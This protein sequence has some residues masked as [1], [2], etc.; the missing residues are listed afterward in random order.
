MDRLGVRVGDKRV[1]GDRDSILEGRDGK[2]ELA[3]DEGRRK[4]VL[5]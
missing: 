2:V 4:N 1:W 3:G 5:T